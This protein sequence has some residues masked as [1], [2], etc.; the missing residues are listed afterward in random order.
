MAI[1]ADL[2]AQFAA[3]GVPVSTADRSVDPD[4][5][6]IMAQNVPTYRVWRACETQWRVLAGL[7]GSAFLGLD[8][9]AVDVVLRRA[10]TTIG[11]PD[12]VFADLMEMEAEALSVFAEGER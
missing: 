1:D 5:I 10:G 6:E 3:M 11:H 4:A 9:S 7:S 12:E 8:Y 2:A